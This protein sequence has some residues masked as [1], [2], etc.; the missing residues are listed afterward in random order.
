M[1]IFTSPPLLT[2]LFALLSFL[3][4]A[5]FCHLRTL[6]HLSPRTRVQGLQLRF[7]I[8]PFFSLQDHALASY[9]PWLAA[10][11]AS[12][13]E[14]PRSFGCEL[15]H[16]S[17]TAAASD[18]LP[19]LLEL[20]Q[21]LSSCVALLFLVFFPCKQLFSSRVFVVFIVTTALA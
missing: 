13:L 1:A 15:S 4:I 18:S 10:P 8:L 3:F 6:L 7:R 19:Q 21:L 2:F 12:C 14:S 9:L 5:W 11:C 16:F 17:S 20:V